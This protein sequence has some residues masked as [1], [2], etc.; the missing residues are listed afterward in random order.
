MFE[1]G[2]RGTAARESSRSSEPQGAGMGLAIARGLLDAQDG[3]IA[4][5]NHDDG[6]Q[7]EIRLPAA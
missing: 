6:C 3:S 1:M 4:V 2:Y 5:H 7:F